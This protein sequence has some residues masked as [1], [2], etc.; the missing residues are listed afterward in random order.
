M[1]YAIAALCLV[2]LSGCA[3]QKYR[4]DAP[5]IA[6][7]NYYYNQTAA[8]RQDQYYETIRTPKEKARLKKILEADDKPIDVVII[9]VTSQK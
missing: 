3:D 2:T 5:S 4:L 7:E 1:K 9:G 6:R 8:Y